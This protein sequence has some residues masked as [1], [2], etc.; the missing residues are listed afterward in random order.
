MVGCRLPLKQSLKH[1]AFGAYA[2]AQSA[3]RGRQPPLA[4]ISSFLLLQYPSAL[5]AALH[6]TPVL[7]A[8]RAAVPNA[9]IT[10]CASG[11]ALEVLG[12]NPAID[13]LVETPNPVKQFGP[14]VRAIGNALPGRRPFATITTTANERSTVALAASLAGAT[15]FVGFTL[16]PELYRAPLAYDKVQSQIANNLRVIA[17]LGHPPSAPFEP[18]IFFSETDLA[19]ARS[20]IKRFDDPSRPLAVLVTQTSPTQRKSWR[21]ERFSAVAEHLIQRHGMN[22]LLLGAPSERPAVQALTDRIGERARNVAGETSLTQLAALLSLCSAG[23]TL[24]TGIL[25]I[26]RAVALPMA[27]IAPAW[28]PPV[29]WLPLDNP[30]YAIFKNLD[31]PTCPPDYI[32]DEVSVDEVIG[33]LD[34]L[35]TAYPPKAP[36]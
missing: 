24:D 1:V 5:G 21:P 17:A 26:G 4:E 25:H 28:S 20:L 35:V 16:L 36:C 9:Q 15:S 27:V 23:V 14:A 33:G 31:L 2:A 6:A 10:V 34:R 32:I 8:L 7:P 18:Q 30:R 22:I 11:F 12:H 3:R 29:E 19:H 13:R